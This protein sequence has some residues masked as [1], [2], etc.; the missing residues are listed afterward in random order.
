MEVVVDY[1]V[2][3]EAHNEIIIKEFSIVSDSVFQA[4]HFKSH[5]VMDPITREIS[6]SS[7]SG[8][9]WN[10]G[11]ISYS[12][13]HTV[14]KAAVAGYIHLYAYGTAIC[15]YLSNLIDRTFLNL[16]EFNCRQPGDL[17]LEF[18]CSFPCHKFP[19]VHCATRTAHSLYKWLMYH[20]QTKANIKCPKD[21]TR[22]SATFISAL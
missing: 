9:S 18:S 7:E 6:N 17:K 2:L 19:N 10:D 12:Q 8:I 4:F 1:S 20:F 21:F 3:K 16:E 5:Y 14:K 13:L 15:E 11:H 22:H